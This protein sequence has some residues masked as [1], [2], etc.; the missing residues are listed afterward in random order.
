MWPPDTY[1]RKNL[2][3]RF[4]HLSS[5]MFW[6]EK[7]NP[8]RFS[9]FGCMLSSSCFSSTHS[10]QLNQVK[11]YIAN[12][13]FCKMSISLFFP[14]TNLN[15]SNSAKHIKQSRHIHFQTYTCMFVNIYVLEIYV[16]SLWSFFSAYTSELMKNKF[17]SKS[18]SFA[19]QA[20]SR[21]DTNLDKTINNIN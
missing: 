15:T 19:T 14:G 6:I 1:C 5:K 2:S 10:S 17:I 13:L 9:R 12:G 16:I 21:T 3:L 7:Q 18:R 11:G 20:L 4:T 8:Q